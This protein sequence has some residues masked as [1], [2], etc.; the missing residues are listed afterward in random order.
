V[1]GEDQ[2]FFHPFLTTQKEL[3]GRIQNKSS[4]TESFSV[5]QSNDMFTERRLRFY[6]GACHE[7]NDNI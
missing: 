6:K 2:N 3:K 4:G 7:R 1:P 5:F